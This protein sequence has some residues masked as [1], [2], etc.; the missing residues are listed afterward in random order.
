MWPTAS[1]NTCVCEPRVGLQTNHP[2]AVHTCSGVRSIVMRCRLRR[3][4]SMKGSVSPDC[5][6]TKC[7][8]HF[9][10]ILMNVSQAISCTP[11]RCSVNQLD[12]R[13]TQ[14]RLRTF[15]CLVHELEQLVDDRL[16]ELPVRLEET[17][18][19]ADDVHDVGSDNSFVIFATL[20]LGQ[21]EQLLDDGDKETLFC[22]F[23]CNEYVRQP[24]VAKK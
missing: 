12:V 4:S 20:H 17:R 24:E 10:A 1:K 23:V 3:M 8:R 2:E 21:A 15:V 6:I 14:R 9:C 5:C 11:V 18:I 7:R 13:L 16:Q 19:L 22:L